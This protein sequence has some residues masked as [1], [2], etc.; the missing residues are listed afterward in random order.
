MARVTVEDCLDNLENRF[1]LVMVA[2]KRARQL[3]TGGKDPKVDWEND[4]PTVVALREI[5][6]GLIDRSILD[7]LNDH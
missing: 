4:K 6:A 5:S 2:S 7:N 1:E 3:A